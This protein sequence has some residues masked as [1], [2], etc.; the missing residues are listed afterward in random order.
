MAYMYQTRVAGELD[1][2]PVRYVPPLEDLPSSLAVIARAG[3]A[4]VMGAFGYE[5]RGELLL[6]IGEVLRPN[7]GGAH[8]YALEKLNRER[9]QSRR[10]DLLAGTTA[11]AAVVGIARYVQSL[12]RTDE[13]RAAKKEMLADGALTLESSK[14]KGMRTAAPILHMSDIRLLRAEWENG[15]SG[16]NNTSIL[17]LS[18][19]DGGQDVHFAN[20]EVEQGGTDATLT[21]AGGVSGMYGVLHPPHMDVLDQPAAFGAALTDLSYR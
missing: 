19:I 3:R 11:I 4:A 6:A 18:A 2:G 13:G 17:R 10:D 15:A 21:I 8:P 14:V 16:Q 7:T 12:S 5:Q 1:S 9:R 20:V